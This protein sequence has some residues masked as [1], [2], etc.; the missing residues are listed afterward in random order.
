MILVLNLALDNGIFTILS[1]QNVLRE[2]AYVCV[3]VTV[4]KLV[5]TS[6]EESQNPSFS[7]FF[8]ASSV[9]IFLTQLNQKFRTSNNH[10]K[11][12]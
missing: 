1:V 6:V 4:H 7:D 10:F 12:P 9:D 11:Q 8:A 2:S 3:F 5:F